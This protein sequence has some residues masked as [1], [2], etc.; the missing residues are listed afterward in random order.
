MSTILSPDLISKAD[1][2]LDN[3]NQHSSAVRL[4]EELYATFPPDEKTGRISTQIRNLEQIVVSA[5]RFCD[6]E[7]F[8]KNQM[9][10]EG[11]V[12]DDWRKAGD[13]VLEQLN[14]LRTNANKLASSEPERLLLRLH[15]ARGWIRAVV[16]GYLYKKACKQLEGSRGRH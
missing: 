7:D 8:V 12:G 1:A 15:L 13:Q 2:F 9:G 14:E 11:K 5:T 3:E 10:R 6:I 4:G 16:G